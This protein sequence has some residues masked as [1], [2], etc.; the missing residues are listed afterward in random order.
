MNQLGYFS[1]L[2]LIACEKD[3]VDSISCDAVIN[4]F[5]QL[6]VTRVNKNIK[7]TLTGPSL[8][9][10]LCS[11]QYFVAIRFVT[12]V[13]GLHMQPMYNSLTNLPRTCYQQNNCNG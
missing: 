4:R 5:A 13:N 12:L 11:M 7:A 10:L 1:A 2:K 6:H 3:V 9:C 8:L